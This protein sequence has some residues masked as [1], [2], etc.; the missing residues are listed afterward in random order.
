M[1]NEIIYHCPNKECEGNGFVV[2]K[3]GAYWTCGY[4]G[5]LLQRKHDHTPEA[6]PSNNDLGGDTETLPT[7]ANGEK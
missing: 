1:S 4:C 5:T 2:G 7:E 3:E 6:L